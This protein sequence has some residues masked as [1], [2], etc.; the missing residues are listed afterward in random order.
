M[1]PPRPAADTPP[2]DALIEIMATLRGPEGCPWDRAQTLVSL[3]PF[4]VEE[5]YEV[6]DAMDSGSVSKHREE[7]GDLL[8]QVVFQ[9]QIRKEEGA[10]D[11]HDV[12]RGIAQKLLRRHEHVW[13][14]QKAA[15]ADSAR[16]TWE[17]VKAREREGKPASEGANSVLDGVPRAL[18]SL[19]RAVR[20]GEKAGRVGFD[21]GSASAV[22]PKVDEEV[23]EL[24]EALQ[25]GIQD[26]IEAELGD[27][28]FSVANLSRHLKIDPEEALR[29]AND[30]FTAR[31]TGM[32]AELRLQ[33]RSPKDCDAATWDRLWEQAKDRQA[34]SS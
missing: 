34:G 23:A 12:C 6:L 25:K 15:D 5:L 18:P 30:R 31:F 9:S 22:I 27:L 28:L 33:G 2:F 20:I 10:F 7:L 21:W 19:L 24:K 8:L 1:T 26:E 16:A 17:E 29:R 14:E 3:K 11:V 32:E 13:G 4:A